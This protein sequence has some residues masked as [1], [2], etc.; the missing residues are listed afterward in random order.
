MGRGKEVEDGCGKSILVKLLTFH[1]NS[2]DSTENT[3]DFHLYFFFPS[4]YNA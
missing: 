1:Y 4:V 3:L 2:Y